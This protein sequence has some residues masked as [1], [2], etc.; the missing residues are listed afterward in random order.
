MKS[1]YLMQHRE[2]EKRW[3]LKIKTSF[4]ILRL[5]ACFHVCSPNTAHQIS[6]HL[7]D[8]AVILSLAASWLQGF[9]GVNVVTCSPCELAG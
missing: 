6:H 3:F 8:L 5:L 7:G 1:E 4:Y 9:A 2:L